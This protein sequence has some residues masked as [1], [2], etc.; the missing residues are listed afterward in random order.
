MP[1]S[2]SEDFSP[3]DDR[4][5]LNCAHQGPLPKAAIISLENVLAWK[6]TPFLLND[7]YFYQIPRQLKSA[8]GRLI[9]VPADQ[10]ILGNSTSYG[11]H[12]LANG[13]RWQKEDEIL[14]TAG[15]FPANILPWLALKKQGV[16]IRFIQ[17]V[18]GTLSAEEF[19]KH[20]S[21]ATRLFCI[22]WVNSFTGQAIDLQAIG[23]ICRAHEVFFIINGSQAL[24]CRELNVPTSPIDAITSCGFKWLCGPYATGFCWLK[25]EILDILEYNQAYWLTN[26]QNKQL[27]QMK[28]Y[29]LADDL[30]AA[31]FDVFGTA[32]FFNFTPWMAAVEYLL[33]ININ[34][35]AA[36]DNSLVSKIIKGLD[37]RKYLL[38]SPAHGPH[39][40]TLIVISH[41]IKDKN[42]E[43]FNVLKN[44]GIYISLREDN[45]RISPH[46]YN[47]EKE[48]DR[49]L[50]VLDSI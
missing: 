17:P 44:K 21:P 29:S 46:L 5:W 23:E 50:S 26:L 40:S 38:I 43:I 27:N 14:L 28:D 9:K 8:L 2:Y 4:I 22:S 20:I 25:P 39:R 30:G 32:N 13:I 45:L 33:S 16:A 47:T 31:K 24:G 41:K 37:K 18:N 6:K 42:K 49:L 12:I 11:L 48:I 7:E 35:V 36:Y 1:R 3:F 15:D 10:I 19:E 34:Q